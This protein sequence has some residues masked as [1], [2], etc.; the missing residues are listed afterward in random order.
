[1]GTLT[2]QTNYGDIQKVY[3]IWICNERIPAKLQNTVT[4]YSIS[5][6]DIIGTAQEPE[7]DYDLMNVIMIRRGTETNVPIFDYLS[8]VFRCDKDKIAKYVDI[9][10]NDKV[11]K[12]VEE[13]SGLGATIMYEALQQGMQEGMQQGIQEGENLLARLVG[14]LK[15]DGRLTELDQIADEKARKQLYKEYNLID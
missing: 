14:Y 6:S 2:E 3:S 10:N 8:G 15:R 5:K 11:L 7:E 13:M 4:M 1:M 12:G 9:E